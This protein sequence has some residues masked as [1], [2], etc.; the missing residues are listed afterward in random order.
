MT[1]IKELLRVNT[2]KGKPYILK[3][4]ISYNYRTRLTDVLSLLSTFSST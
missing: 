1:V 2:T 3:E 4:N